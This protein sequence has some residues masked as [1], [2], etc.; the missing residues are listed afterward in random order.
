MIRAK[1]TNKHLLNITYRCS[2][3]N[4]AVLIKTLNVKINQ[5]FWVPAICSWADW[6]QENFELVNA[7]NKCWTDLPPSGADPPDQAPPCG[8][9]DTCKNITFATSLRTV[10]ISSVDWKVRLWKSVASLPEDDEEL[11]ILPHNYVI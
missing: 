7:E 3:K 6:F 9:T 2:Y 10:I 1:V 5:S 11:R 8:Q 4:H